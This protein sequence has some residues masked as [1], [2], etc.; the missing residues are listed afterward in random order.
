MRWILCT[1]ILTLAISCQSV[2][3][4]EDP[5]VPCQQPQLSNSE[6]RQFV[7]GELNATLTPDQQEILVELLKMWSLDIAELLRVYRLLKLRAECSNGRH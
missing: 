5:L 6:Q 2:S 7:I 1:A 4:P 3:V